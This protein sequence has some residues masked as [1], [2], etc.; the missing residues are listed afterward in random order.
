MY[1]ISDN[2]YCLTRREFTD[3]LIVQFHRDEVFDWSL[4]D[5]DRSNVLRLSVESKHVGYLD[6]QTLA[7]GNTNNKPVRVTYFKTLSP[8][9]NNEHEIKNRN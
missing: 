3:F 2:S 1:C 4:T 9:L 5:E 6:I 8:H 7:R